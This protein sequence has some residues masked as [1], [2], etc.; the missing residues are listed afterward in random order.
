MKRIS[1]FSYS[2]NV[3]NQ[4]GDFFFAILHLDLKNSTYQLF[5]LIFKIRQTANIII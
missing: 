3:G 2:N 5:V 4:R 1:I